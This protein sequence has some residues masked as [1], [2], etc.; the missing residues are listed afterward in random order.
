MNEFFLKIYA[1]LGKSPWRLW[2]TMSVVVAAVVFGASR[3]SVSENIADF[4][5]AK[6]A[7]NLGILGRLKAMDRITF[8]L[9]GNDETGGMPQ[10][11]QL[12]E[13]A[14]RLAERLQNEIGDDGEIELFYG[15]ELTDSM[16]NFVYRHLPILLNASDYAAIDSAFCP[17]QVATRLRTIKG[18]LISPAG[19]EMAT[20]LGRDPLMMALPILERLRDLGLAETL[21]MDDGYLFSAD[22][23]RVL[24][25]MDL[26]ADFMSRRAGVSLSRIIG[27][28]IEK[29]HI[30]D[31]HHGVEVYAYGAP[32]VT[33]SNSECVK[34]DEI[35]TLSISLSILTVVLL[36]VF[37][38]I[39]SVVLLIVPVVFGAAFAGA[40]VA[41]MG[42]ELSQMALGTG[43]TIMGLGL[44]YSIHMVTHGLHV[45]SVRQ[46]IQEM[47]WPMT[48]GSVTTIGAFLALLFTGS[49]VLRHLGLFASLTL[50]GTLLFCLVF[51][52][53]LMKVGRNY[54]GRAFR[55][56]ERIAGY[57][58]SGNTWLSV[59]IGCTFVVCL[60]FFGDVRFNADMAALNYRGDE[61]LQKSQAVMNETLGIGGHQSAAIVT[62]ETSEELAANSRAFVERADS[63]RGM[64]L[65]FAKSAGRDFLPTETEAKERAARWN[66]IFTRERIDAVSR[67]LRDSG[68]VMG[69][70]PNAFDSFVEMAS[71]RAEGHCI[72]ADEIC[73]SPLFTDWVTRDGDN[74]LLNYRLET[75]V[76][77][78]DEI[79]TELG[80]TPHTIIADMG[81]Y[82][83]RATRLI[84]D[85][86]NWL[87][88]LSSLIVSAAL[89]ASYG[90]VE[91]F[92]LTFMPMVVGWVIILG[93][94]TIFGVE[95]NVVNII[96]STFIFGVGDDYSIFIMDGLQNGYSRGKRIMSGHKTAILLSAFAV[97]GGLGAQVFGRHP[98]VHS[99]GLISIFGLMAVIVTSFVVQPILFRLLISGPV[100]KGGLPYTLPSLTRGVVSTTLFGI[101]CA[102]CQIANGAM[103]LAVRNGS[104]RRKAARSVA[105]NVMRGYLGLCRPI[106]RVERPEVESGGQAVIVSNHQSSLDILAL[107]ASSDRIIFVVKGWVSRSVVLGPVVESMGFVS[108]GDGL[109]ETGM[110]KL[111]AAVDEGCSIVIFPEGKRSADGSVGRFHKGAAALAAEFGLPLRP[112]VFYGNGLAVAKGQPLNLMRCRL[113]VDR[114]PDISIAKGADDAEIKAKT[115]QM[116]ELM[117]RHLAEMRDERDKSNIYFRDLI[118]RGYIYRGWAEYAQARRY[119]RTAGTTP[120][121]HPDGDGRIEMDASPRGLSAFRAAL[122]SDAREICARVGSE[123]EAEYCRLSPLVGYLA[124]RGKRVTFGTAKDD[125]GR[126]KELSL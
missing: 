78:R 8:I 11:A 82:S 92:L 77:N 24:M 85:D 7:Q 63:L 91:L 93:L 104:R 10:D 109:E 69:F 22:G 102:V 55:A 103:W 94:M 90:R 36:L 67:A 26:K 88:L 121:P 39:R 105:H 110:A 86:F 52:P 2:L 48:V 115:R 123:E 119:V 100:S 34:S 23:R 4:F 122:M 72:S 58:Y 37:R 76:A 50:V 70:S 51:L 65:R 16:A 114:L 33:E 13:A 116:Q 31:G 81:Y 66:T 96:L 15:P 27:E 29:L 43:A 5:P 64:G 3:M 101:A 107:M 49:T 124:A 111:R 75:E 54:G 99:L 89:I 117:T 40:V 19:S 97:M 6:D 95:F 112:I 30:E 79:L 87:L 46:L 71:Q 53:H 126:E 14:E 84:V 106:L 98:A 20:H 57:D 73:A 18:M 28:S 32:L 42:I 41:A 21:R 17:E 74:I 44:S 61:H 125:N 9:E 47:A 25:F 118:E 120:L 45:G 60:F 108:V 12:I 38:S 80:Q 68:A 59:A 113:G 35:L 56:V 62:G 83:R 1:W